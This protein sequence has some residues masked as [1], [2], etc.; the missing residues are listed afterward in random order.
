MIKI[1]VG[2]PLQRPMGQS[3]N[4][5]V[6]AESKPD[7]DPHFFDMLPLYKNYIYQKMGID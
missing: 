1:S 7:F 4:I 6:G 5:S 2:G 3:G